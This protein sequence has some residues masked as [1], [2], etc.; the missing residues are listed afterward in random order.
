MLMWKRASALAAASFVLITAGRAHAH[1][2]WMQLSAYRAQPNQIVKVGLHVGDTYPGDSFPRSSARIEKFFAV[3]AD[4]ELPILGRD[5]QDP[6]GLVRFAGPG[7]YVLGYRSK[8]SCVE[9]PAEKFEQYLRDKGLTKVIDSRAAA[10]AGAAP[11]R[12]M[13]SR[14]AKSIVKVGGAASGYDRVIGLRLELVPEADP[15]ESVA[16]GELPVRLLYEGH[17]RAGIT[18]TTTHGP[19]GSTSSSREHVTVKTDDQGRA[20]IPV[21]AAGLWILS[22]VE[23]VPAPRGEAKADWESLWASLTFEVVAEGATRAAPTK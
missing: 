16:G 12:E 3:G 4:G 18:I 2:F 14:C 21:D 22:A 11:G 19:A 5:G 10:G 8:P 7:Q 17:P 6:A 23:M 9:L 1:D 20:R 13:F 15:F